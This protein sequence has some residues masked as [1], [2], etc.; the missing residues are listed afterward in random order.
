MQNF[1]LN[2]VGETLFGRTVYTR[3]LAVVWRSCT[4]LAVVST[5]R[6]VVKLYLV[7]STVESRLY[8]SC[9]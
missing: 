6:W 7:S 3:V 1:D 5:M 2:A 4:K 9:V 8:T